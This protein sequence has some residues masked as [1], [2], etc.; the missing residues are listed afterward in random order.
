MTSFISLPSQESTVPW[1]PMGKQV[2]ER[3]YQRVKADGSREEW[4]DTVRRVVRGNL[5]LV[6]GNRSFPGEEEELFDLFYNFRALPAGRHLWMS[7]VEGR[8]FLFNCYVSGWGDRLSEHF[9]F[10]FNQ[11]MEGGGVGANYSSKYL[12]GY[13]VNTLVDVKL[14]CSPTHADYQK[15]KDAGLLTNDSFEAKLIPDSREGW[16]HALERVID[17]ASSFGENEG[18]CTLRFDLSNIREEGLPIKTFGGTSAGP[19]PLARLLLRAGELLRSMWEAGVIPPLVME[20]D[21]AIAT[22]VVSGNVRRSARMAQMHW[23]DPYIEWFLACKE[24]S[25]GHWST[26][27]SVEIDNEFIRLLDVTAGSDITEEDWIDS[28]KA[29]RVYEAIVKG[30]LRNGEPG[31][32][33]SSLANV[34]EPNLVEATNPCGEIALE[35]WENCN[36]GHINLSAFVDSD[37]RIDYDGLT[38]AHELMARFLIRATYGDITV[39]ETR[40]VVDRNRRIGVGHF[41]FAGFVAKQGLKWSESWQD[42]RLHSLLSEWK[43]VV[44]QACAAYAHEL[45]IPVP[46]KNTAIAPTGSI[47]K[48]PGE[49]PSINPIYAKYMI[50]RIRFSSIDPFQ[51]TQIKEYQDNGYNVVPDPAVPN[52]MVVEIPVKNPLLSLMEENGYGVDHIEDAHEISFSDQLQVQAMY[53]RYYVDNSISYTINVDPTRYTVPEIMETLR[54]FLGHVKGTTVFPERSF[55]LAPMERVDEATFA[56][57]RGSE[58]VLDT[59]SDCGP[60]GCPVR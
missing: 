52:T 1:G 37:G 5:S 26:N 13:R 6:P 45:R 11:L 53:Q 17:K 40:R 4:S 16:V 58:R 35:G 42:A 23:S 9:A 60:I 44:N 57:L 46:V 7:G 47:A 32:W 33:N 10:T 8:Q 54:P 21:H 15:L 36:L 3:T 56:S 18:T 59:A 38:R 22:C 39:P 50:Q 55:E 31:I 25:S 49:E 48:M 12:S 19:V 2:Y 29:N 20:L 34:G 14:Y 27:I 24:D 43:S 28:G 30:M 51:R 41:G